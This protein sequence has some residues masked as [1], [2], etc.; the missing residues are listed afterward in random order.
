[1]T[2][3]RLPAVL[4]RDLQAALQKVATTTG[5]A[6]RLRRSL[7]DLRKVLEQVTVPHLPIESSVLPKWSAQLRDTVDKVG[8]RLE[9]ERLAM[10]EHSHAML[11]ELFGELAEKRI[12]EQPKHKKGQKAKAAKERNAAKAW[13]RRVDTRL[14]KTSDEMR[15][16]DAVRSLLREQVT[17]RSLFPDARRRNIDSELKRYYR[18]TRYLSEDEPAR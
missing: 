8:S 14:R 10:L 9:R 3:K 1:M 2:A 5:S 18:G 16:R 4:V 7:S 6:Q 12:R 11:W 15:P 17:F 13:A